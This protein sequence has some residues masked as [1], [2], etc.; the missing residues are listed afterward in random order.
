MAWGGFYHYAQGGCISAESLGSQAEFV[1][2]GEK[3][4]FD[5]GV[6]FVCVGLGEISQEGLFAQKAAQLEIA[7]YSD[8]YDKGGAG[9]GT[10]EA[11]HFDDPVDYVSFFRGGLEHFELALILTASSFCHDG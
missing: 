11:N 4:G 1:D 5:V 3:F 8:P 2:A 6:E 7:A 10:G 9:I